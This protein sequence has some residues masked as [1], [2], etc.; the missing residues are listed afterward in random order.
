V[1]IMGIIIPEHI[2]DGIDRWRYIEDI[3]QWAKKNCTQPYGISGRHIGFSDAEDE[4]AFR[5]K[6]GHTIR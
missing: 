6:F 4:L 2:K 1:K 3:V 5:L